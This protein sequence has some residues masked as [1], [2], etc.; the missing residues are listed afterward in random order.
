MF[1]GVHTLRQPEEAH[2][3]P[4]QRQALPVSR[5]LQELHPEADT[6]DTH[7]RPPTCEAIQMQGERVEEAKL[8]C[9]G[10]RH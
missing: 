10:Q 1:T 6:Q 9:L 5:L 4:Q 7:D 3:D 2:A 8:T